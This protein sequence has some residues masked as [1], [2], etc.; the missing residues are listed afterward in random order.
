M[1]AIPV[2]LIDDDDD[3]RDATRQLLELAGHDVR[4]FHSA[5]P[6]LAALDAHFPGVVVTDI[7]MP[8]MSGLELF[9]ALSSRDAELPV[10]LMTGHGDI[11]MAVAALKSGAWDF[12]AKPFDPDVLLAAVSRAGKARSLV[13]ENRRLRLLAEAATAEEL[14]GNSPAIRHLR[15]TLPMLADAD[16][17]VVV[18]GAT[19]TG[20]QLLARLIHRQGRRARHRFTVVD[21]AALPAAA[22]DALFDAYGT[23]SRA[24][25]GT[26]F[27][28]NLD[29]ADER[30]QHRLAQF[31]ERR[32]VAIDAREPVP[33]NVRIVAAIDE[34]GR[35]RVLPALFHRLA[36][37]SLRLPPLAE[38]LEDVPLLAMHFLHAENRG[39]D[40]QGASRA[41][42]TH[43][44]LRRTWPG[45][46][47]ELEMTVER[48]A[49]GLGDE[50]PPATKVPLPDRMRTYERTLILEAISA[51]NGDVARVIDLL[52]IPRETF[53]Y[54]VKRL[55][56]DLRAQ[57]ER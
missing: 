11:D 49:L 47:R 33:V 17:D 16:L 8:G 56:I 7:R 41:D 13:L 55:G 3:L 54:R 42:V 26:L 39:V 53:Y 25:R 31:T 48:I 2:A 46:V 12:L 51:S 4:P 44:A 35:E 57:R 9:R 32:T 52:G 43:L 50:A 27:L 45:N 23:L 20:K 40:R 18:E 24:D 38:R 30:L 34:G 22:Q 6:A 37:V 29:R 15:A 36:A 1:T 21:C 28:D 5:E 19:G 14:V 10:I